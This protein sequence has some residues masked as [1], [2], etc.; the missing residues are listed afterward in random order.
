LLSSIFAYAVESGIREDNPV[1]T[2][3][4]AKSRKRDVL[5]MPNELQRIGIAL[6]KLEGEDFNAIFAAAIRFCALTGCRLSEV[7]GLKCSEL[8]AGRSMLRSLY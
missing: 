6:R 1:H 2:A 8:D 5:L 4:R 7:Q 3:K